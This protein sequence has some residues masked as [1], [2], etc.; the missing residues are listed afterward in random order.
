M[1]KRKVVIFVEGQTEQQFLR[2]VLLQWYGFDADRLGIQCHKLHSTD[3]FSVPFDYGTMDSESFYRIVDASGEGTVLP[4]IRKNAERYAKLG[5]EAVI[6]LRDMFCDAYHSEAKDR[7]IHSDINEKMIRLTTEQLPQNFDI[8]HVHFAIMEIETWMLSMPELLMRIDDRLTLEYVLS[9]LGIDLN[10]DLEKSLYHPAQT[11]KDV[12]KLV[13]REYDK[14]TADTSS[15]T[16]QIQ[17]ED[18]IALMKPDKCEAFRNF[19]QLILSA[20][21]DK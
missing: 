7:K 13:G 5:Y 14:H 19:M 18:C 9:Q 12:L 16:S 15:V 3:E 1:N 6:G 11:M 4:A 8:C 10:A 17:K 2:D 21:I 20:D